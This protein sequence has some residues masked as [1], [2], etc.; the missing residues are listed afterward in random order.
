MIKLN[1]C[2]SLCGWLKYWLYVL[3][4]N[5]ML[6]ANML[7]L[8]WE[9]IVFTLISDAKFSAAGVVVRH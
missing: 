4:L 9:E 6:I 8:L 7:K 3:T 1:F 5:D 2:E